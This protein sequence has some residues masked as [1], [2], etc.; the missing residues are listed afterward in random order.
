[1]RRS[2]A[3]ALA[4]PITL[5]V[6]W[7][8]GAPAEAQDAPP[9]IPRIVVDVRGTVPKFPSDQALAGSRLLNLRELP[10]AGL[11]IDGGA[12]L[13]VL[14]WKATTFGAGVQL[15]LARS[16]VSPS[17]ADSQAGFRSVTER[18]TS[19]APQLSFN[20]GSGDG[21]SYLSGGIGRSA[22]SIVPDGEARRPADDERLTTINYGGGARWFL[23]SH[24]AFTFDVRFYALDS[25]TPQGNVPGS[26]RTTLFIAGAGVSLK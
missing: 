9:P 5:A 22:W 19:I 26:P 12:H 2:A 4:V 13:A 11:G 17:P 7:L 18:F 8:T 21:W 15:T 25:G 3:P 24:V 10:G 16:H 20:F 6:V 1:M 14:K 23:K